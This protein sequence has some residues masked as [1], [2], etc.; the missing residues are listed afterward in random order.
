ML[1]DIEWNSEPLYGLLTL[2]WAM[3]FT[4]AAL[5]W[6]IINYLKSKSPLQI[7]VMDSVTICI[8]ALLIF[9][10]LLLSTTFTIMT[11]M[12]DSGD[13]IAKAMTWML[14]VTSY[15]ARLEAICLVALQ[16]SCTLV[17]WILESSTFEKIYKLLVFIVMPSISVFI[18]P[19]Q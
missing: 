14:A 13:A 2:S 1:D 3:T 16:V 9:G 19:F 4:A 7:T 11:F 8:V 18:F 10:S 12:S 15:T 6:N 17:P 5:I